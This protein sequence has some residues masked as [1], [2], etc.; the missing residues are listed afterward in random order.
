[1]SQK[2]EAGGSIC[3]RLT[4]DMS[5]STGIPKHTLEGKLRKV[6]ADTIDAKT[7]TQIS[8]RII[9]HVLRWSVHPDQCSRSP[10][11]ARIFP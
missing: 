7:Q 3:Q 4:P 6:P 5:G 1:M 11:F 2:V 10:C 9:L 8:E